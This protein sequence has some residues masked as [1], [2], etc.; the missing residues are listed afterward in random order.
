LAKCTS[1]L[2][3]G[4]SRP[5]RARLK[6]DASAIKVHLIILSKSR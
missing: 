4:D 2:I 6:T 1:T 5:T 3:S